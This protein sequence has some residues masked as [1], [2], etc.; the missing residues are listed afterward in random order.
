MTN[1]SI[2]IG[3][4]IT[5]TH[6]VRAGEMLSVFL[7]HVTRA[8]VLGVARAIERGNEVLLIFH[9]GH[10]VVTLLLPAVRDPISIAEST[11]S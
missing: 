1:S 10:L 7:S 2:T 11:C 4:F 3:A 8:F 6:V 9:G 5:G